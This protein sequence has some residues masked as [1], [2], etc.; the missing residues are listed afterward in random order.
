MSISRMW[1]TPAR[2]GTGRGNRWSRGIEAKTN[3][4]FVRDPKSGKRADI[5]VVRA[6]GHAPFLRTYADGYW[7]DNLLALNQC[8]L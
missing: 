8:P 1:E 2:G 4:F 7:S 6:A 3:T 5:G